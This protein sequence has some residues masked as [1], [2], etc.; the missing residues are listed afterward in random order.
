MITDKTLGQSAHVCRRP[1]HRASAQ[2]T[3]VPSYGPV[4]RVQQ[5]NLAMVVLLIAS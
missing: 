1:D 2:A 3:R 4:T 5:H